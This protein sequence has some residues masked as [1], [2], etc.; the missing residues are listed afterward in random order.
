[1]DIHLFLSIFYWRRWILTATGW[2]R[3]SRKYILK[4]TQPSQYGYAKL[5]YRFAVTAGSSSKVKLL[6]LLSYLLINV[7]L[8]P[9]VIVMSSSLCWT[10]VDPVILSQCCNTPSRSIY[11]SLSPVEFPFFRRIPGGGKEGKGSTD[12]LT[13][14][15]GLATDVWSSLQVNGGSTWIG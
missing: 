14:K 3:S 11:L 7:D 1:M 6:N 2:P 13:E 9:L 10:W 8:F 4:I 12:S 15:I 5:Q